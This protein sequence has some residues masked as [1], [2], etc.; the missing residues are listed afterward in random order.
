MQQ[1]SSDDKTLTIANVCETKR[2]IKLKINDGSHFL[3]SR[4]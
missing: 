4:M 2:K 3:R 1:N